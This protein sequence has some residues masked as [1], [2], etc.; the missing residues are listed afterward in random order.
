MQAHEFVRGK[1]VAGRDVRSMTE[2]RVEGIVSERPL[3]HVSH[4][5]L[6]LEDRRR[7]EIYPCR[8]RAHTLRYLPSSSTTVPRFSNRSKCLPIIARS[9]KS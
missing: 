6:S 3:P 1:P 7:G 4:G 2:E 9:P 5:T 8:Y